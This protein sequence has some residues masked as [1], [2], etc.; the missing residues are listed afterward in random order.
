MKFVTK[1]D[2]LLWC[3]M[4]WQLFLFL[5]IK[6]IFQKLVLDLVQAK[7]PFD[8]PGRPDAPVVDEITAV[9]ASLSW[10]PPAID[11]GAE[12]TNYVLEY[13]QRSDTRWKQVKDKVA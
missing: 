8:V 7:D 2:I 5:C 13:K 9:S 3:F 11:G 10:S 4:M 12:I 1:A 6:T